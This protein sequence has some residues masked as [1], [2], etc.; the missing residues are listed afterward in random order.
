ML[1]ARDVPYTGP[2]S[3]VTGPHRSYGTDVSAMKWAFVRVGDPEFDGAR[4]DS[5]DGHFNA[6]L[7]R[8]F[9]RVDPGKDGYG[10]GRWRVLRSMKIPAGRP[11]AGEYALD[12]VAM[13]QIQAQ[14]RKE[15]LPLPELGPVTRGG[16][17]V[18][19]FCLSHYTDGLPL[20]AA[21]D[22]G[23]DGGVDVIAPEALE[24]T[25]IGS[26]QGGAAFYATGDSRIAYWF[27]HVAVPPRVG[28]RFERGA[29]MADVSYEPDTPH[30]HVGVN[31]VPFCGSRLWSPDNYTNTPPTLREQLAA[32]GYR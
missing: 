4:R 25:E 21:F 14:H 17:S 30:V 31:T 23:F 5:L 12:R 1:S 10:D 28:R 6:K 2:L 22:T 24:V 26:A 7:E 16:L 8:A 3:Q 13:E 20:Y 27:G 18:L 32:W 11:H 15:S 19:D 29:K 9:D